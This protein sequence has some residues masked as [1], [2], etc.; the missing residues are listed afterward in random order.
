MEGF[1]FYQFDLE[2][3]KFI[4]KNICILFFGLLSS[5]LDRITIYYHIEIITDEFDTLAGSLKIS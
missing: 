5:K 1:Q 4:K 2:V 3:Y